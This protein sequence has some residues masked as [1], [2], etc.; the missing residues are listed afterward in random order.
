MSVREQQVKQIFKTMEDNLRLKRKLKLT[1]TVGIVWKRTN[2]PVCFSAR[3]KVGIVGS[4]KD[5]IR[6][7]VLSTFSK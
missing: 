2:P 5:V 1:K 3:R 7:Y 6:A 4:N